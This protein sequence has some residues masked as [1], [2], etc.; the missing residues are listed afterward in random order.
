VPDDPDRPQLEELA[1]AVRDLSDRVRRLERRLDGQVANPAD[2][3]S[4]RKVVAMPAPPPPR[5]ALESRIGSQWLN[6]VG[7][8]AVLFG[9]AYLLRY[10][11]DWVSASAWVWL[12]VGAGI[13]IITG[14][15]WF[16]AR[17]YRVLSL[18]LKATGVGITYLSLWAG[19]ELYKVLSAPETFTGLALLVL[20]NV[21]L[22]LRETSQV[23]AA[24][25]LIGG[26]LTPLLISVPSREAPLFTWLAML[27]CAT[28]AISKARV[29][30]KL[31]P[32]S[33]A[34][35]VV[36]CAVWY[37]GNFNSIDVVSAAI[38]ATLFFAIFFAAAS[39]VRRSPALAG[40]EAALIAFEA[41]NPALYYTALYML[42]H[43]PHDDALTAAAF[44][45]AA[46]YFYSARTEQSQTATATRVGVYGGL[47]IAF[48]ALALTVL[49][50]AG[51]LSLGWFVEAAVLMA[52]GF[53]RDLPWVRWGALALLCTAVVKAFALDV[54]EL[55]LG[56]RT[57]SFIALGVLLLVIS[58]AYQRYGFAI[59]ASSTKD[60]IN[61]R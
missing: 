39:W 19:L 14:S 7:V 16:R 31:L 27:D 35:T 40:D 13:V 47:G 61:P 3:A 22:A 32:L 51:W 21:A 24:L 37:F 48:V 15:E 56:Y 49:L 59:I 9:V 54:W 41:L 50:S 58:F 11:R 30:W 33:F 8:V 46:I 1:R 34:G 44:A 45:L 36:L 38:A 29:W 28:A 23:L 5:G 26:F 55:S 53:W 20:L 12:G 2:S 52:I 17:G 25:A 57:L 4:T 43:G 6:R 10:V 18:S 60:R 42:L